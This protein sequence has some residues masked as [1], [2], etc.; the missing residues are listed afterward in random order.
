MEQRSSR[1]GFPY[2]QRLLVPGSGMG[3]IGDSCAKACRLKLCVD[4]GSRRTHLGYFG[5]FLMKC[6]ASQFYTSQFS[7]TRFVPKPRLSSIGNNGEEANGLRSCV[8]QAGAESRSALVTEWL[9]SRVRPSRPVRFAWNLAISRSVH[10]LKGFDL[11]PDSVPTIQPCVPRSKGRS[12]ESIIEA[13]GSPL[14]R[15]RKACNLKG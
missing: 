5:R 8:D 10:T 2:P 13:E 9:S 4:R 6:F 11:R 7:T 12:C 14:A 1:S 3:S 15:S